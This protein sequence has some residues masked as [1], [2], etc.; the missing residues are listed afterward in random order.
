MC[1]PTAYVCAYYNGQICNTN[2]GTNFVS[3]NTNFHGQQGHNLY[4]IAWTRSPK[5]KHW[6]TTTYPTSP[7]LM[8]YIWV[9]TMLYVHIFYSVRWCWCST[10]VQHFLQ[11]PNDDDV[12][13][14]LMCNEQYSCVGTIELLCT[15]IRTS[16]GFNQLSLLLMM[17]LCITTGSETYHVKVSFWV[18]P[19]LELI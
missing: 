8:P 11:Q 2:E 18:T 17:H 4:T 12:Y 6:A 1:H 16:D 7:L 19:L 14:I 10:N 5:T 15:I 9:K 13:T 3:N